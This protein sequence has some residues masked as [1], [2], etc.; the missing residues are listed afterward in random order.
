[1]L[2][3]RCSL[4]I[5]QSQIQRFVMLVVLHLIDSIIALRKNWPWHVLLI[6][7]VFIIC[8]VKGGSVVM[9]MRLTWRHE[10]HLHLFV[11][12][13]ANFECVSLSE[14][15]FRRE[16]RDLVWVGYQE[17]FLGLACRGAAGRN[18]VC[19]GWLGTIW[20]G[21]DEFDWSYTLVILNFKLLYELS[22][23]QIPNLKVKNENKLKLGVLF[24]LTFTYPSSLALAK[25]Y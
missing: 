12:W 2:A 24:K 18:A 10:R 3:C 1:M 19:A 11:E 13:V 17:E 20:L 4:D 22:H 6:D 25:I 21:I 7:S 15:V 16:H 14:V 9:Q 23:S 8:A 5:L